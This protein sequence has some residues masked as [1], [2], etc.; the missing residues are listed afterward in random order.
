MMTFD[1]CFEPSQVLVE[2]MS[3]VLVAAY[4]RKISQSK[5]QPKDTW[6]NHFI[7]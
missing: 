7:E 3:I 1:S 2:S 4:L 6:E 5:R